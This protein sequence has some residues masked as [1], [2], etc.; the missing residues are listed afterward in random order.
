ML[1]RP[2]GFPGGYQL[3]TLLRS[4]LLAITLPSTRLSFDATPN[5]PEKMM[6]WPLPSMTLP[7][8]VVF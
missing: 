7:V 5:S 3:S 8:I 1:L 6:P 2:I 4:L